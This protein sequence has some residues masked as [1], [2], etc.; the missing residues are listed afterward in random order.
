MERKLAKSK[1]NAIEAIVYRNELRN[2]LHERQ[3]Q[4][5]Q[6][7]CDRV[8]K[9]TV[10]RGQGRKRRERDLARELEWVDPRLAELRQ[11]LEQAEE[12]AAAAK[13][14]IRALEEQVCR[15]TDER[16]ARAGWEPARIEAAL[17]RATSRSPQGD[18]RGSASGPGSERGEHSR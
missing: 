10:K 14:S 4:A 17:N 8:A 18:G 16:L 11:A 15:R 3:Q 12:E 6:R 2:M 5:H 13:E 7:A 1:I 9:D